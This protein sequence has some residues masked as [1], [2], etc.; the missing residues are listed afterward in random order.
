MPHKNRIKQIHTDGGKDRTPFFLA[1]GKTAK[2]HRFQMA[3][4]TGQTVSNTAS[5]EGIARVKHPPI[6]Q[7][8]F[9]S[10]ASHTQID[11]KHLA[12]APGSN[13]GLATI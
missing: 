7:G 11:A 12:H 13:P 4:L 1:A 9:L 2:N 8:F 6:R 10:F 3:L 5:M